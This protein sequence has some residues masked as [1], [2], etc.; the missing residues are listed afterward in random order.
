MPYTGFQ[1][2]RT[3]ANANKYFIPF[4]FL[5]YVLKKLSVFGVEILLP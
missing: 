2:R 5:T 3:P 4:R 1:M